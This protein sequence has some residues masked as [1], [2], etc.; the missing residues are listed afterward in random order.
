MEIIQKIDIVINY[1]IMKNNNKWLAYVCLLAVLLIV[2]SCS[3]I[4]DTQRKFLDMGETSY[5]GRMDSAVAYGGNGRVVIVTKNTY[6]RTAT[7]CIVRWVDFQGVSSEKT[8]NIKDYIS[9]DYTRMPIDSLQEGDYDFYI[10]NMD[11]WENKSL[12]VTCHGSSYGNTYASIQPKIAV[13]S[14]TVDDNNAAQI[15]FSTSKMAVKFRFTYQGDNDEEKTIEVNGTGGKLTIPNWNNYDNLK[16]KVTT[17]ILPSEKLG[18]DTLKL[19][20]LTQTGKQTIVE[21]TVDKTIIVP[22]LMTK[23]DDPGTSYGAKG[24]A[25]LFDNGEAECWGQNI[26]APG[27]FCFDLGVKTYLSGASIIGRLDYPGWDVVKFEIWGR[28]S[29]DDGKYGS[30][31]YYIMSGSRDPNFVNEATTRKWKKVGNG[32][33]KYTMPRGNPQKSNCVLT[34]VDRSIKPRYIMFRVMSVLTPDV[35]PVPADKYFGTEGG[36]YS[37]DG[38]NTGNRAFCIKE[39]DFKALGISYIIQ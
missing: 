7:K 20:S 5:V 28:E 4:T 17:Y 36:F 33:F 11:E 1:N 30:T 10:Y 2:A 34:E 38:V 29:I 16:L 25:A 31:G 24:I 8:F 22:M 18:I 19:A 32:W 21:Y 15:N 27:H 9:G 23:N 14:I 12:T 37:G 3:D 35:V 6:L 39:L 13:N 26:S